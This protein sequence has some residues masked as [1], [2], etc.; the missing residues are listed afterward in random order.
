MQ[1]QDIT[2]CIKIRRLYIPNIKQD[3]LIE[4]QGRK[5]YKEERYIHDK[6]EKIWYTSIYKFKYRKMINYFSIGIR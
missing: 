2:A 4:E 5:P 3:I 1:C 6:I